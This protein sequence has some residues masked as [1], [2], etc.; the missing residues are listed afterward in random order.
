MVTMIAKNLKLLTLAGP[1]AAHPA[2]APY[3][4]LLKQ[5]PADRFPTATDLQNLLPADCRTASG[6]PVR[7]VPGESLPDLAGDGAYEQEIA[8]S[9]RISTRIDSLHDVCNALVWARFPKLKAT[10]NQ[11]H[12]DALPQSTPGRRGPI[13]DALTLF[14]ECGMAVVCTE[15]APLQALADH[16]WSV[17]FGQEGE[18]WPA[19]TGVW[20]IGHGNLEKLSTPYPGMISQCILLHAPEGVP[21]TPDLDSL[22]SALWQNP[23]GP[24]HPADLCAFPFAGIPGWWHGPQDRAFYGDQEV[25]RPPRPGRSPPPVWSSSS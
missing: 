25:F 9:G 3:R 23:N 12:I 13:R 5:L 22:L 14:D 18:L 1:L 6:V 15:K 8:R 17:L 21:D 20:M 10:L 4:D 19:S 11:R 7:M 2:M 16:D 24:A